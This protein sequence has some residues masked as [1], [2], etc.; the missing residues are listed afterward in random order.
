MAHYRRAKPEE[1]ESYID[2]ANYVFRTDFETLLPKVYGEGIDSSSMHMAAVDEQGRIRALTAVLPEMLQVY[3][4]R[5]LTGYLGTVSVH[6]RARGEGHMKVLMN[7][8]LTE[9]RA[10]SYDMIVLAGQRQRYEYFG[11]TVGGM[12]VKHTVT[13]TNIRHVLKETSVDG[14]SFC[15]LFEAEGAAEFASKLNRTRPAYIERQNQALPG[16]FKTFRLN[17]I[18]V[19]E[20]GKL[21]GYLLVNDEGNEISEF[22]MEH[23]DDMMRSIKAYMANRHLEQVTIYSPDYD[24]ALNRRLGELAEDCAIE[25][26]DMYNIL[27]FANVL[28]AYLTLKHRTTGLVAGQ[29]SAV[30]DGQPITVRVDENGV[31]IERKA[32]S[33]AVTLNKLQAQKLLLTQHSRYM[34]VGAPQGWFPLPLFW[35]KADKF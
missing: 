22:A 17:P 31:T 13:K 21:I 16:I 28:Q 35:Y 26:S 18:G 8:W 1:R 33:D 34:E 4:T 23:P 14:L 25:T 2:F 3:D 20:E 19:L 15:P 6:P 29:F 27:D 24:A 5:L 12:S 32:Q 10:E 30:M 9:L 7:N 11:F